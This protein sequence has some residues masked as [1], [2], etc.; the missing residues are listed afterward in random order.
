MEIEQ[1]PGAVV[2][3]PA[4][5]TT[6]LAAR[7]V[8][9][10]NFVVNDLSPLLMR[11]MVG[12]AGTRVSRAKGFA[13][14]RR[15]KGSPM[16]QLPVESAYLQGSSI[17]WPLLNAYLQEAWREL[18][19]NKL[20]C[21]RSLHL[22]GAGCAACSMAMMAAA[23]QAVCA[24]HACFSYGGSLSIPARL[25]LPVLTGVFLRSVVLSLRMRH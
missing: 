24:F 13:V 16:R 1:L 18:T 17:C 2:S 9:S 22:Q 10:L 12:P 7:K 14:T 20:R 6:S 15:P 3:H 8:V 4:P 5:S 23:A 21:W 19:A 25:L 11:L